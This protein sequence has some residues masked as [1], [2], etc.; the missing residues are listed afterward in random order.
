[1]NNQKKIL[2]IGATG[3][4]GNALMTELSKLRQFEVW[5]TVRN[6]ADAEKYLS[7]KLLPKIISNL[8][9]ENADNLAKVLAKIKPDVVINCVG[10]I[11]QVKDGSD[12]ALNISL[13]SL[14]PHR[15][16][17]LCTLS[18]ARLIH[19]S[20]D[21][22]FSGKTGMYKDDDPSD[23]DDVY[24]KSKALGEVG[25]PHFTIRT[26]I[27]GHG[28]ENQRALIDWFLSQKGK[29]KGYSKVIY[30]GFPTV[31]IA[32][33]MAEYI[34][35]RP[36][37]AGIY[38]VSAEPISKYDLLKLV[39]K[40]Y[41]KKIEI[42]MDDKIVCDRSLDSIRFRRLT[43]FKPQTWEQLV[44]KMYKYYQT[45]KHFVRY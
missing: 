6:Y 11:K 8:D 19:I 32:R 28:L 5:G 3:M 22:V 21:C 27:I 43:G 45:N 24:G 31:E 20:T 1:M 34:I 36:R 12:L 14:F 2:I 13:N 37:L 17:E 29:I 35:P 16:A 26:S 25:A 39:A 9:V 44:K 23:A 4:L 38:N 7:P 15:L 40:V 30:S 10:I 42:E 33:I 18:G 41:R